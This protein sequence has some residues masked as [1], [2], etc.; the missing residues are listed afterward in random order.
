MALLSSPRAFLGLDI[1]SEAMKL[2]EVVNRGRRLELATYA[3]A[4]RPSGDA[5]PAMAQ[6][7]SQLLD[8]AQASADIVAISLPSTHTFS[9]TLSLPDIPAGQR[10]AA[11]KFK[12][13]E[14]VPADLDAVT[15]SWVEY[16]HPS[17]GADIYLTAVPKRLAVWYQQLAQ[18][19][20]LELEVL[21]PEVLP[22]LRTHNL[23]A[24]ETALFC[25]VGAQATTLHVVTQSAP[26]ASY[27]F[28]LPAAEV[29][30]AKSSAAQQL[31]QE[32]QRFAGPHAVG[33][34]ILIGDRALALGIAEEL[35]DALGPEPEISQPWHDLVYPAAGESTLIELGPTLAVALGL[36]RRHAPHRMESHGS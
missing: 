17:G 32:S 27:T 4:P 26:V 30:R 3:T 6:S 8:N 11:I 7:L 24:G 10:A 21:E 33:K 9:A 18:R 29:S 35:R 25:H 23:P 1:G 2:V 13:R 34:V 19:L 28:A 31:R 14:I 15:L 20:H 16:R 22:L 12:A 36:A 5:L